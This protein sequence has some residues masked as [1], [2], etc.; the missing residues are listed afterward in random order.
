MR[1][2]TITVRGGSKGVPGKNWRELQ[3]LPL[4]AHSLRH[5]A[6]SG[7]FDRITV[8]TDAKEI[9][10]H[11]MEFGATD[12]VERPAELAA[13]TAGKVP[14][15]VHAVLETERRHNE[16]YDTV[17][18]LD[19]TSPL[20]KAADVIG[21]VRLLES[22]GAESVITARKRTARPTSTLWNSTVPPESSPCRNPPPPGCCAGR[23]PRARST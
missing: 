8:T 18:D 21:A 12:V 1:L 16:V 13:D 11:A 17:V 20:R 2:C 19:A 5:A 22:T 23:T 9:L 14:A 3:G 10:D 6:D 4:Y 15:I 7:L